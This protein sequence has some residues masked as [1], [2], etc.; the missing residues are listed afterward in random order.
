MRYFLSF[1]KIPI[2]IFNAQQTNG[3]CKYA[4]VFD[5]AKSPDGFQTKG[6]G[7]NNFCTMQTF[8]QVSVMFELCCQL[9]LN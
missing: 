8:D 7:K 1:L 4:E 3:D 9:T 2:N 6:S 5:S